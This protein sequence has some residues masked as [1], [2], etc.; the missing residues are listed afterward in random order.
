MQICRL[1]GF[2]NSLFFF[3]GSAEVVLF[4]WYRWDSWLL[5][6]PYTLYSGM[7]LA[8]SWMSCPFHRFRKEALFLPLRAI[9]TVYFCLRFP[10]IKSLVI[11]E[12]PPLDIF[13]NTYEFHLSQWFFQDFAFL[14]TILNISWTCSALSDISALSSVFLW[15][16]FFHLI[17][18]SLLGSFFSFLS[19]TIRSF[20]I[21]CL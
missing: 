4:A 13:T 9:G 18:Y 2:H 5:W 12:V 7:W 21:L 1:R 20:R 6:K 3:L 19:S 17:R 15:I 8:C 16:P 14:K 11:T 10:Y